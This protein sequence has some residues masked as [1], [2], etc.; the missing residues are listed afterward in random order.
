MKDRYG[1]DLCVGHRCY[2]NPPIPDGYEYVEGEWNDG[3]IIERIHD[4]MRFFWV[5]V[6]SLKANGTFDGV[7]FNSK[8][9]R[10][11][12]NEQELTPF[13]EEMTAELIL[14][15]QSIR[16][17][18]GFYYSCNYISRGEDPW[19]NIPY[20][21]AEKVARNFERRENLLSHLPFGAE[22]DCLIQW[23]LETGGKVEKLV[24]GNF[25]EWT[26]EQEKSEERVVRGYYHRRFG[27][28]STIS[29][30]TALNPVYYSENMGFRIALCMI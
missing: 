13:K 5:P 14:Q 29:H 30:R 7:S 4:G 20:T 9:G 18:K 17:Y 3:F 27:D 21:I 15:R 11:K 8:F 23:N 28:K 10:R 26:Q 25:L 16:K 24:F 1:K 22:F 6:G 19:V 12:N 2:S